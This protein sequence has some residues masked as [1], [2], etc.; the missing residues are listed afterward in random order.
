MLL[1]VLYVDYR[2]VAAVSIS[3]SWRHAQSATASVDWAMWIATRI[4]RAR[5]LQVLVWTLLHRFVIK[6]YRLLGCAV[7]GRQYLK[8]VNSMAQEAT[9]FIRRADGPTRH[10]GLN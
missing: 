7:D 9:H 10:R 3:A 5:D 1:R 2:S 4:R 6:M 8:I